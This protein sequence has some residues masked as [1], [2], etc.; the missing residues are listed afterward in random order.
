MKDDSFKTYILEQLR[1][2]GNVTCRAMFG[3]YGLYHAGTFFG[4][5]TRDG[6]LYFKTSPASR[7]HYIKHGMGP[8]QPNAKQTLKNYYEVP[9][10]IIEDAEK[11]VEWARQAV[12]SQ[13]A[14]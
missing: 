4:I 1:D 8:F 9:A 7:A 14:S 3:G 10:E 6:Q 12:A 11:L 2:L 13:D 5:L